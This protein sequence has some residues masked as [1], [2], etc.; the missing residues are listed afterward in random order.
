MKITAALCLI[1][2][3]L[4][5]G[6][7]P[8]SAHEDSASIDKMISMFD[9]G[10]IVGEPK[11]VD[12]TLSGGTKTN[13]LSISVRSNLTEGDM[14]PWCPR[15]ISEGPD[16][17]GIWIH[18]GQ[19]YDVDG[20]FVENLATFY[21]DPEWQL[22]DPITGEI[23]VT[24]TK[25]ACDAAA[26]P[27][28]DAEYN[29]YCVECLQSY[30]AEEIVTTYV[31]PLHPVDQDTPSKVSFFGGVGVAFNGVNFDPPAPAALIL[32][33]HTIAPFDDCG[34]HVNPHT[35]YHYHAAAGCSPETSSVADHAPIIGIAM[36]GYP[37]TSRHDEDGSEPIDLDSCRGHVVEGL[38]Y[39]YHANAIGSN[40]TIGCFTAEIGCN[41]RSSNEVCDASAVQGRRGPPPGE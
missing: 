39:H 30:L 4:V 1:P 23:R 25:A 36:D 10:V 5:T 18:E 14:G 24:D 12:C 20:G 31:L 38:G 3:Q 27:D 7:S 41:L 21:N 29:N 6:I 8:I 17:S 22:F 26:K 35:G 2:I 13:C 16:E 33:A 19:T 34:G 37:L 9:E 40:Q 28:V 32:D 15:N 11:F